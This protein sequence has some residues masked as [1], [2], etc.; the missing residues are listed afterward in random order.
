M[1]GAFELIVY[2]PKRCVP[3]RPILAPNRRK[4]QRPPT[5]AIDPRL[6]RP[7]S[8]PQRPALK[9][10][11]LILNIGATAVTPLSCQCRHALSRP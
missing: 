9:K 2:D 11:V 4:L 7:V 10:S 8:K 3:R 1:G 6:R 5:S